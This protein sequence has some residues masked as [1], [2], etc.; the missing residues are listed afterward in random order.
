MYVCMYE[1][2][3]DPGSRFD[4]P[5]Q[6]YPPPE[7]QLREGSKEGRKEAM[8]TGGGLAGLDHICI[9]IYIYMHMYIYIYIRH[10]YTHTLCI[11]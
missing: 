2:M 4:R 10:V 8:T 3:N 1:C 5:P 11:W 6:W 9:Y 7:A